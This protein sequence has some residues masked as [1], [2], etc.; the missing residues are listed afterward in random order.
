MNLPK[1]PVMLLSVVN[2]KLRDQYSS[3]EELAKAYMVSKQ[4]IIETLQRINYQ[5]NEE[6]NQFV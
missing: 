3:L 6:R 4:D 5:Y 2:T 1:D